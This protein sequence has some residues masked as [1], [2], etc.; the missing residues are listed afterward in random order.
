V[1][2]CGRRLAAAI[3]LIA[4]LGGGSARG[5]AEYLLGPEDVV[6]IT[7]WEH[8]ELSRTAVVRADGTL[9][10]PPLGDVAA[11]GKSTTVL[12]R[13]L[14]SRIYNVLRL[15]TQATVSV[16]SFNSR[17]V[18]LGGQVASPGRYAFETIPNIMDL[19]SM[20]GG[21]SPQADL[22]RIRILR[23]GEKGAPTTLTV[24][25]SHTVQTGDLTGVP[26]LEPGDVIFVPG[27]AGPGQA[28]GAEVVYV[29]GEVARPGSYT[30]TPGMGVLQLMSLAGG[31]TPRADMGGV[32]VLAQAGAD[33]DYLVRID[34]NREI[35]EGRSGL[36]LKPGDTVII[37]SRSGIGGAWGILR[38]ALGTTRDV[39][40][41]DQALRKK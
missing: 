14:E 3:G 33:G 2:S 21:L 29:L 32:E 13:E 19:L 1:K 40:L 38:E 36:P 41:I 15:S 6:S 31:M 17:A 8:P 39:L 34:L 10:L 7:V 12:A 20:T 4:V 18:Y 30:A 24:D 37:P 26:P 5:E 23:K 11:A 16:V 22:S 25:L 27:A 28:M 35:R 9:T